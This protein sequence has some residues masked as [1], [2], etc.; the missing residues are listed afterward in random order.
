V[1]A[2]RCKDAKAVEKQIKKLELT[3]HARRAVTNTMKPCR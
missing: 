2:N 3:D 1:L